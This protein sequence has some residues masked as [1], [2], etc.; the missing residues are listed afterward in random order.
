[1]QFNPGSSAGILDD[2]DFL[3]DT[4]S[5]TYPTAQKTRNINRWYDRAVALFLESDGRWQWDDTNWTD[6]P[7]ATA[8]LVADQQDY[9]ILAALPDSGE[10]YLRLLRVEVQDSSGNWVKLAPF[11]QADIKDQS[12]T[13]FMDTSGTPKLYEQIGPSIFLYPAPATSITGGLK[14]YFQ[15]NASYFTAADTTK[16]PGFPS[17]FHRYLSYGASY[18]YALKKQLPQKNDLKMEIDAMEEAIKGFFALRNK[19][20]KIKLTARRV[21]MA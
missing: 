10:D 4:S 1:M 2:I 16:A 11:D 14:C 18:D 19:D 17:T 21:S 7:I 6:L 8:N 20:E 13:D 5:A 15:R 3:V 9:A 12:L